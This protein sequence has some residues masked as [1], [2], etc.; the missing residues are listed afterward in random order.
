MQV[1]NVEF[2]VPQFNEIYI[3]NPVVYVNK[4]EVCEKKFM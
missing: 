1:A 2:G 4:R 3:Y